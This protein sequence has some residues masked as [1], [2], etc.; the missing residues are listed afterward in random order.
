M[1]AS[2]PPA[3][4]LHRVTKRFGKVSA[5]DRLDLTVRTGEFFT[6]LGPSGCGKTTLL[7]LIAGLERPEEGEI[8]IAG[9]LVASPDRGV[10]VPAGRRQVGMV[11]QNFA[12]WPHMTV[13]ENVAFGLQARG[14]PADEQ[15]RSVQQV[16]ATLRLDGLGERFPHELSGGQ[17]QRVAL[18]RALATRPR[19]LLMDEPLSN[20]DANLRAA[21]RTELKR[22]HAEFGATTVYVTHD[23]LEALTLSDRIAV[24]RDGRVLQVG[25]PEE[26][27]RRPAT[28]FVASFVAGPSLNLLRGAVQAHPPGVRAGPFFLP[29]RVA[30]EPGQAVVVA[31]RSEGWR[32]TRDGVPL[33]VEQVQFTGPDLLVVARAEAHVFYVRV[34]ADLRVAPGSR[35]TLAPDP[36]TVNAFDVSAEVAVEFLPE[37]RA[38]VSGQRAEPGHS[39]DPSPWWPGG[40]LVRVDGG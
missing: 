18:A 23:Q 7:R 33:T 30:A 37:D 40:G 1:T 13:A 32:P 26:I 4:E 10:F 5:V 24:M 22:L 16:L 34:P 15:R 14:I 21:M 12:L 2:R 28:L 29:G 9:Q 27:Y 6:L 8:R 25:T 17:Q 31:I 35:L 39:E 19:V 3:I 36:R 20:L 11:F 38:R